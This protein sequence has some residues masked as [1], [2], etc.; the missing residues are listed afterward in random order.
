MQSHSL[1]PESLPI[2]SFPTTQHQLTAE[3]AARFFAGRDLIDSVLVTNSIA[4]GNAVPGSDLDM[5]VLL[6]EAATQAQADALQAEWD[7]FRAAEPT[8]CAFEASGPFMHVHLDVTLGWFEPEVWD[9]GGGPDFFEI[10]IGNLLRAAPLGQPGAHFL[11]LRQDWLPYY[12]ED[13][14][15]QRLAMV[16]AAC[17]Y[18]LDFIPF[19]T[20]R[21][22]VFQAFDRLYRAHQEFLQALFIACRVYPIAYNKWIHEQVV[23]WLGL[24]ALY[25]QLPGILALPAL[26][27]AMLNDRA[28]RLGAL[29]ENWVKD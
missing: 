27:P 8:L 19:Y 22:L 6:G 29:L 23:D 21:G 17:R 3:T 11:R 5:N 15:R 24:P 12:N 7:A 18:D 14:R 2:A 25:D 26:E 20:A 13:L 16:R 28:N 4:R 1:T 10:G 9:D